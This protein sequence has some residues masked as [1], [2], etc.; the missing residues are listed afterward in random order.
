MGSSHPCCFVF[1]VVYGL[2]IC[3]NCHRPGHE[4]PS[5]HLLST[6]QDLLGQQK[7]KIERKILAS[8][9]SEVDCVAPW[10]LPTRSLTLGSWDNLGRDLEREAEEGSVKAVV[11]LLWRRQLGMREKDMTRIGH[12]EPSQ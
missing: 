7:L 8:F 5:S 2:C 1:F 12:I 3:L 9:L 11:K 4:C 6:L 10:F